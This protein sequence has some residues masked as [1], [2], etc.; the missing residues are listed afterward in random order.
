MDFHNL[1][2]FEEKLKEEIHHD[3]FSVNDSV[4]IINNGKSY[5]SYETGI[6]ENVHNLKDM[7]VSGR[8]PNNGEEGQI[9]ALQDYPSRDKTPRIAYVKTYLTNRLFAI[10]V[11]GLKKID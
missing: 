10:G 2:L 1:E 4:K 8:L 5:S 3:G 11:D 9:M 6:N 7:W